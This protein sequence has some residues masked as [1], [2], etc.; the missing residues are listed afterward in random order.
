MA[1]I[2][3][4]LTLGGLKCTPEVRVPHK[5][6]STICGTHVQA[7][8]D[9]KNLTELTF[10][11]GAQVSKSKETIRDFFLGLIPCS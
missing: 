6:C 4:K 2:A 8:L 7:I 11:F 1:K 9:H 3:L 5:T 10:C